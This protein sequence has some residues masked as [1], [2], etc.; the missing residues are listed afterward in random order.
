MLPIHQFGGVVVR[1]G[2]GDG[3]MREEGMLFEY[4]QVNSI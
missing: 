4:A 1:G 3:N 2:G